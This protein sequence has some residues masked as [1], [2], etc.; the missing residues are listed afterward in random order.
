[1]TT[2][3]YKLEN[4][5]CANCAAKMEHDIAEIDGVASAKISFMTM[6]MRVSFDDGA[7][8]ESVLN[9]AQQI[10]S[11]YEKDCRIVR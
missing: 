1:M 4:L 7:D 11:E 3:S 6:K 5:D 8:Q 10:V 2:K 9:R